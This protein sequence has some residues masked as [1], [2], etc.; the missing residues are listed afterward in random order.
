MRFSSITIGVLIFAYPVAILPWLVGSI[1][2]LT[3]RECL[4]DLLIGLGS[5]LVVAASMATVLVLL[6]PKSSNSGPAD[7]AT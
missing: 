2:H 7:P 3:G 1:L 5:G 6:V 4:G